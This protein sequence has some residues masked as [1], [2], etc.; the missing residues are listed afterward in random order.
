[1]PGQLTGFQVVQCRGCSADVFY[2]V[3]AKGKRMPVDAVASPHGNV[4]ITAA[5]P[6]VAVVVSKGQ[7]AGMRAAGHQLYL[8]H[9]ASCVRADE[10][11]GTR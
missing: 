7:A 1:M 4:A 2:A 10:F 11:R 5:N 3:T 6:P 9:F 8:S